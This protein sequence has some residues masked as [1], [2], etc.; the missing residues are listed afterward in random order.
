[1]RLFRLRNRIRSGRLVVAV[2]ELRKLPHRNRL[3]IPFFDKCSWEFL[4]YVANSTKQEEVLYCESPVSHT[5]VVKLL[6][7][8][9]ESPENVENTSRTAPG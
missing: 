7:E 4:D 6:D 9:L 2:A 5:V 8:W 3:L 1:M